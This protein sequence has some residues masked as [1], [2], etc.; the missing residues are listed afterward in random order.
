MLGVFLL[1]FSSGTGDPVVAG[2]TLVIGLGVGLDVVRVTE[3]TN[4]SQPPATEG[5]QSGASAPLG[6]K[7][8]C[9]VCALLATVVTFYGWLVLLVTIHVAPRVPA[10]ERAKIGA[11]VLIVG[12]GLVGFLVIYGLWTV[13]DWG[14]KI[15]MGWIGV[16]GL[17]YVLVLAEGADMESLLFVTLF[18][19]SLLYLYIKRS[20]YTGGCRSTGGGIDRNHALERGRTRRRFLKSGVLEGLGGVNECTGLLSDPLLDQLEGSV[21]DVRTPSIVATSATHRHRPQW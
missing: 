13:T 11:I 10:I 17:M 8:L 3:A 21:V 1:V 6:T 16:G 20:L 14:W 15:A 19:L 5:E 2:L 4:S 9:V 12:F 18:L 7:A